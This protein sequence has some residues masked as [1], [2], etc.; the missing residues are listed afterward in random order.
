MA[1]SSG[2]LPPAATMRLANVRNLP[3]SIIMFSPFSSC[4]V[5]SG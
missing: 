5:Q 2:V 1:A 3:W 4:L